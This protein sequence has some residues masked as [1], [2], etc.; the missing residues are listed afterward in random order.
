M[1]YRVNDRPVLMPTHA[2]ALGKQSGESLGRM[3]QVDKESAAE[4]AERAK[5]T[6]PWWSR[7][8]D[9][10]PTL[11]GGTRGVRWWVWR[12]RSEEARR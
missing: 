3:R 4:V 11:G 6:M 10:I 8:I 7:V 2:N 9:P 12:L 5:R 1:A